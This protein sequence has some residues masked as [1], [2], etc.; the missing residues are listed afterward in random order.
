M[1]LTQAFRQSFG[2]L[3]NTQTHGFQ[4]ALLG[5][6][7]GCEMVFNAGEQFHTMIQ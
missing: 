7:T 6:K 2:G 1:A 3:H 4:G 5:L